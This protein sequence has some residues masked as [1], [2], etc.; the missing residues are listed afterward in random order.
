MSI[1]NGTGK[2]RLEITKGSGAVV[3]IDFPLLPEEGSYEDPNPQ[4]TVHDAFDHED[5]PDKHG[6]KP[7]WI[8]DFSSGYDGV[9][10]LQLRHLLERDVKKIVF[11]PHVD[12]PGR[13]FEVRLLNFGTLKRIGSSAHGGVKLIF[14][15][16][17]MLDAIPFPQAALSGKLWQ[18]L[19][20]DTWGDHAASVWHFF[21]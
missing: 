1:V 10:L 8:L 7:K 14:Q 15:S 3:T 4:E 21:M 2:P 11:V 17:K 19:D 12:L 6:F 5:I 16:T 20:D 13:K 9:D 18:D